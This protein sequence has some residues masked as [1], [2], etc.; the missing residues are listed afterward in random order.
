ML[1]LTRRLD[2]SIV[3]DGDITVTIVRVQGDKVRLG[4]EAPKDVG[5][6][7]SELERS[8]VKRSLA[9]A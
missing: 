9:V 8:V 5:V 2:E 4:I 7:R 6:R 3:I 1:V